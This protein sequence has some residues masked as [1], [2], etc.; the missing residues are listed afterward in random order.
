MGLVQKVLLPIEERSIVVRLIQN[1]KHSNML[2]GYQL[3]LVSDSV[4]ISVKFNP[5]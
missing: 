2:I 5:L 4:I 3:L 1:K